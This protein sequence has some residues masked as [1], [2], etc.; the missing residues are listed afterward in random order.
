VWLDGLLRREGRA[1]KVG[2]LLGVPTAREVRVILPVGAP[3]E[4]GALGP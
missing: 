2:A 4:A 3:A 1:A